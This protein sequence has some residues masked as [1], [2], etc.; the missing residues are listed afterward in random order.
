METKNVISKP[1]WWTG[2]ILKGLLCLFLAFDATMKLIKNPHAVDGTKEM[3]LPESS[4]LFLGIYLLLSTILYIYPKTVMA[5]ILFL[6]AYLGAAA[7]IMFR[8]DAGGHPY[9]FP[10]VFAVLIVLAEFLRNG[11]IRDMVP[12]AK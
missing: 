10:I 11:K 3:G 8:T 1:V 6:S 7:G 2:S 9:L 4:L 5:G 12:F